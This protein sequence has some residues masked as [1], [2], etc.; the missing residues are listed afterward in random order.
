MKEFLS[1][2]MT[3]IFA[4]GAVV[5]GV[6]GGVVAYN[7]WGKEDKEV[8][9]ENKEEHEEKT[10]QKGEFL[11]DEGECISSDT[12]IKD[13]DIPEAEIPEIPVAG[14]PSPSIVEADT[15]EE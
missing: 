6:V 5:I 8:I 13:D 3:V 12:V 10:C 14:G 11:N 9:A 7:V 2:Y 15:S 1:K 4:C